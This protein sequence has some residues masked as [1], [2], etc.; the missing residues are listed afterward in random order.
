MLIV[1][2][3]KGFQIVESFGGTFLVMDSRNKIYFTSGT[4][5]ESES[6]INNLK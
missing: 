6:Y 5:E 1:N 3:I 2:R 4:K